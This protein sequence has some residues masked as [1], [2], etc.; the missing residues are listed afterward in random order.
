RTGEILALASWPSYDPNQPRDLARRGARNRP[1]TDAYEPGS[2]M[3][4]FSVAA[5]IDHGVVRP[6]DSWDCMMGKLKVGG[7]TIHD[8]HQYGALTT[9]EVVAK[10]SNIGA[11][12]IAFRLGRQRLGNFLRRLGFAQP[13]GIEMPG[14]AAGRLKPG[15][16][17][18]ETDL[19]T[20]AFGQAMTA[21]P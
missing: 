4:A 11:A 3:K 5:A 10:S 2:T 13:T 19:A 17:W 20:I 21:T 16:R 18:V 7:F 12:K 8:T 6:S 1:A 9:A 15:E 14:E